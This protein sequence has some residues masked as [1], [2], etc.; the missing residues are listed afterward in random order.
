MIH[1]VRRIFPAA[2][3]LMLVLILVPSPAN[4]L[5]AQS[6]GCPCSIW[7]PASVPANA[8]VSDGQPIEEVDLRIGSQQRLN[9]TTQRV[10][11]TSR[12]GE[13]SIALFGRP[14]H[15]GLKYHF[16]ALPSLTGHD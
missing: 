7:T 15:D 14:F 12:G 6:S 5:L 9:F 1:S 10:V 11:V 13:N 16:H 4:R 2:L 3:C 8:A